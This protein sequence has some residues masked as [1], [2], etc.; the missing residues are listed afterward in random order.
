MAQGRLCQK[1]VMVTV[2]AWATGRRIEGKK[3]LP[4]HPYAGPGPESSL[5]LDPKAQ[6]LLEL[7]SLC[8]GGVAWAPREA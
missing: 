2:T 8:R 1:R 6:S 3:V 4:T 5:V 7:T